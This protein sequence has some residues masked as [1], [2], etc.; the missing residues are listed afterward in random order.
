LFKYF[1]YEDAFCEQ[2]GGIPASEK[3]R[4][5]DQFM[6]CER[7]VEE[8]QRVKDDISATQIHFLEIHGA[9]TLAAND[10]CSH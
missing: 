6:V 7:A 9:L 8:M 3:W 1:N 4:A 5:I 10:T 2:V